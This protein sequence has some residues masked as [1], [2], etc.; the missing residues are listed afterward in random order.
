VKL[1]RGAVLLLAAALA[2]L[3]FRPF[4]AADPGGLLNS[5]VTLVLLVAA[6]VL[7][8]LARRRG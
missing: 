2:C 5:A 3:V 4:D 6:L 1:P 7:V 8:L